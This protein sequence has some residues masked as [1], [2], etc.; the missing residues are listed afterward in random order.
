MKKFS[1]I[2]LLVV[3]AVTSAW[4]DEVNRESVFTNNDAS[5]NLGPVKMAGLMDSPWDTLFSWRAEDGATNL[6]L[7]AAYAGGYFWATGGGVSSAVTTD[8]KY[9]RYTN[10][11]AIIDSFPQ[12]TNSGWGW[13]DLA[14][15]GT[16][17]YAGCETATIVAFDPTTG[18]LVPGM[19][20]PKP[21]ALAIARAL[22]YDPVTD[23]FWSGNFGSNM[24]EFDRSGNV[25]W[26]GSPAPLA[27]V[28]GLA[29][30]SDPSGPCLWVFD[31]GGSG[32]VFH[33][34]DP[35][36]HTFTGESHS[37]P[38]MPGNTA[39]IAGGAEMN[40][41]WNP[42]LWTMVAMV[43]GTPTDQGCVVEIRNNANPYA[44]NSPT[45]F[46]LANNGEQLIA[47]LGWTNPTTTVNGNPLV[48]INNVT[49][50]RN[51]VLLTALVGT[52]GQVMT[53]SDNVPSV[54]NYS[55]MV[56]CVNDSGDGI[57][58][59]GAV[60]IGL[61]VPGA[62]TGVSATNPLPL[63]AL[64]SWTDPT[65]GAH[66][67][68]WPPGS[69]T[70]QKIYRDAALIQTLLGTNTSYTDVVSVPGTYTYG[71][72]YYNASGDGPTVN[73]A[74]L[75]VSG[76]P[77]SGSYDIGGG[78]ND[79]PTILAAVAALTSGGLA[80]SV[81]F[82]VYNGTYDGQ[83]NLPNTIPGLSSTNT[84]TIQAATGQ[85]P[86]VVNTAGTTSTTGNGFYITGADYITIKGL[87]ITNCYYAGIFATYS[88]TD[89][90]KYLTIEDNYI[91]GIA[92]A[93]TGY[94]IYAYRNVESKFLNNEIQGDYYG[95]QIYYSRNCLIANNLV[96]GQDYYGIRNYYGGDNKY[97]YNSVYLNSN[98]ATTNYASYFYNSAG[99]DIK[100]NIFYNAGSGSTT[101]YAIYLTTLTT[102]PVTS[103]YNDLYAPNSSVGY[104]AAART[105]LADWQLA[106]TLDANSISADPNFMSVVEPYN[107]HISSVG[108]SFV[109]NVGTPVAEVTV[110]FDYETRSATT[111]DLGG[112]EY[113]PAAGV[114]LT[115]GLVNPPIGNT[116][117]NFVYQITY[118]NSGN[119]APTTA[120]VY[121]DN[122]A[123][124]LVDSTGGSGNYATGVDF[125][126]TTT[127]AV[128]AHDY[129][130]EFV[131]NATTYR[132]PETGTLAGPTVYLALTGSYD[133]GGGNNDFPT[134]V[135]AA[136]ALNS[137]GLGGAVTLNV[138]N[139]TYD[140][141]VHLPNTIMG[142]SETNTLMIKAATGQNPIVVNTAGTSSTTGSG[143]YVTGADYITIKGFEITNCYYAGV[144]V[145]YTGSDSSKY[146]NIE[147]NYIHDIAP[148][149]SGYG[150][151]AYR[152]KYGN[153]L[154]N[155]VQ[156]DYYGIVPYY[157]SYCL[158]ANN[159]VYGQ[160]Y[161]GIRNYYGT[162]NKIYYNSVY[163]NSDY[164]TTN[165]ATYFY[166][167][168]GC[169]LK[170]NIFFNGG[171]GSTTKYA[172]Y[173][174]GALATYPITSDYNDLYSP[175]SSVGYYTAAQANLAAWQAAT[176]L[177]ANSLSADPNFIS[178][179]APYDLHINNTAPSPVD[180]MANPVVEVTVDFDYEARHAT[181]PDIGGDEF[182]VISPATLEITLTPI[183]PPIVIPASGG[184]FSFDATL[185]N[186]TTSPATFQAWIKAQLPNLSWYPAL[187]P[188]T[189][190]LPASQSLV[191]LRTQQVPGSAPAGLYT[192]RGWVG[193][194]PADPV[195][196]SDFTFTKSA[197]GNGP[198]V[199]V[200]ACYGELFPGEMPVSVSIPEIFSLGQCSP[201]PF[202]PTTSISYG[203]P[204]AV[205]ISLKVFDVSGRLVATLADGWQDA[206]MHQVTFDGSKLA[207]GLYFVQMRAADFNSVNKMMLIK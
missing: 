23:H 138:F 103:D 16:Y 96:Y 66:M 190:T 50:K 193:T 89:S 86:V 106:T 132:F 27:A 113:S 59:S 30:D 175:N 166:N 142:L 5:P 172:I 58:V 154:N 69:W 152:L 115:N 77:F 206:G 186:N 164:A 133:I 8:N 129:Y 100:D 94:G 118:T 162:Y 117:T 199:G 119:V 181:T 147:G 203:L 87:E 159:L 62:P 126:H 65:Q 43:Q 197:V 155:K 3:L 31:Q 167:A 98:Y 184:S 110:D 13:R 114:F 107:L 200:W 90:S 2:V 55:Y 108:S 204:V 170:N 145:T 173:I 201:N 85:N 78:N 99:C 146:V 198:S 46:T 44:P 60:W 202:N 79:Y 207:S 177:D 7:G 63:Q 187:G 156:G 95:M 21:A 185:T 169:D 105:S 182:S 74:P 81:T 47:S 70:G 174:S 68:Y 39:G 33:K 1:T 168:T 67:G 196:S 52:P 40:N 171:S 128:G 4:A 25:I 53:Y 71:V 176:G 73:A 83:V 10:A 18:A 91:H 54:G 179:V 123:Y 178:V 57:P 135:D 188:L 191:R 153:I 29:W 51:G 120:Q 84:L 134:I 149:T 144:F 148:T 88:S 137:A 180:A 17:L 165:Y 72:A 93:S 195:D 64:I 28:Y 192:Y 140:G 19:D 150:I 127:L 15:D 49:I 111:P 124:A 151:Y 35:V 34:F 42:S 121:V 143:F 76:Q 48:A 11:G 6:L 161:Y 109:N 205:R 92:P 56:Y 80:G 14:F 112:D 75:Y 158:I 37:L 41:T 12:P 157:A 24:M 194:Y 82:N 141:Q 97:Y 189:L 101:K 36:T 160:D 136:T 163:L 38:L 22:A 102:Y 104:Y 26:S 32:C 131:A 183:N 130:F 20:F 61:D 125:Y 139:G 45:N 9:Y 116:A 122:V